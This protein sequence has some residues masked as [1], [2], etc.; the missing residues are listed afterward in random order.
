M[1]SQAD[2]SMSVMAILCQ[3]RRL[4]QFE[5]PLATALKTGIP[6]KLDMTTQ[7]TDQ[8]SWFLQ[9]WPELLTFNAIRTAKY[10]FAHLKIL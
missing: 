8:P 7:F 1:E 4:L 9:H 6:R 3:L 5:A 2:G 10:L